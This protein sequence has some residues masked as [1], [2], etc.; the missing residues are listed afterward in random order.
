MKILVIGSNGFIARNLIISLKNI[1]NISIFKISSKNQHKK[2]FQ[3]LPK[4][5]VVFHLA[6]V[7][8][9]SLKKDFFINNSFL[10]KKICD[11]IVKQRLNLKFFYTSTIQA[12]KS[13][14]YGLS[15]KKAED[16][17][18]L[19]KEKTKCKVFIYKLPNIFGKSCLPFYNS[20]IATFCYQLTRNKKVKIKNPKKILNFLYI[21]DLIESFE[22]NLYKKENLKTKFVNL[23]KT[24][25]ISLGNIYKILC[26][27][28]SNS[29]YTKQYAQKGFLKKLFATYVSYLP[30]SKTKNFIHGFKDSRGAFYEILKSK[31][32]GQ[33]SFLSVKRGQ[34]RGDHYHNTKVELFFLV[35][36]RVRIN[37]QNVFNKKKF[38]FILSRDQKIPFMVTQPGFAHNIVNIGKQ[39][40]K[41]IVWSNEI[42]DITKP[43]TRVYKI[44][45]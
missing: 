19:L 35:S 5:D 30:I 41:F 27:F 39:E 18:L 25:K 34:T 2:L 40:A 44:N 45:K 6:G 26:D 1:Q 28:Q 23:P 24:Y 21:D 29:N 38:S 13:S 14:F 9:S 43:D 11:F 4:M 42:F 32:T 12:N 16:S 36:G 10:T 33:I 8:R 22:K 31:D 37:T 7:N 20:V 3:I 17:V 15:K